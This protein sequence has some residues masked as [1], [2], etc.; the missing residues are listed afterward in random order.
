MEVKTMGNRVLIQF[1]A[2]EE[3][4]PVL[5]GH[6]HGRRAAD[7]LRSLREQMAD[8]GPDVAYTA[9]RCVEVMTCSDP[10][11]ALGFGI[12]NAGAVL[13]VED[14]HGD[15]GVYLVDISKGLWRVSV[16][17]GHPSEQGKHG[18]IRGR[19]AFAKR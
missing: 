5:Y 2:G 14:S 4:S 8:R 10:G 9:A 18:G 16:L 13:T 6:W 1:M 15:A 19:I 12:W 3:F 11:A 7:T 17:G